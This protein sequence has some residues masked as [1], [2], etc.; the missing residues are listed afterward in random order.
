MVAGQVSSAG[1]AAEAL[2]TLGSGPGAQGAVWFPC[3]VPTPPPLTLG[4][5]RTHPWFPCH[6]PR[7]RAACHGTGRAPAS[8]RFPPAWGRG[9]R[10]RGPGAEEL[11]LSPPVLQTGRRG[12]PPERAGCGSASERG[13]WPGLGPA[14]RPGA[15]WSPWPFLEESLASVATENCVQGLSLAHPTGSWMEPCFRSCGIF[16]RLS[17]GLRDDEQRA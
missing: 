8:P 12:V 9:G 6:G 1:S 17:T 7:A 2:Y 14:A 13:P 5:P 11:A 4:Q 16:K 10:R 3:V 15:G